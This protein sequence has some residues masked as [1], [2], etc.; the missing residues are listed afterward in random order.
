MT[1]ETTVL[2]LCRYEV[3]WPLEPR[4]FL[5]PTDTE[6]ESKKGEGRKREG[7]REGEGQGEETMRKEEKE[8]KRQKRSTVSHDVGNDGFFS[9]RVIGLKRG[10]R[11]RE[12]RERE[13][14]RGGGGGGGSDI[15]AE[16]LH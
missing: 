16:L 7:G 1:K 6:E 4:G 3:R 11:E 9:E 10:L 14:G 5:V 12:G 15:H 2:E 13:R 8:R